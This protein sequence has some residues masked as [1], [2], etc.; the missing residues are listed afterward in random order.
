M[1]DPRSQ[2]QPKGPTA[3]SMRSAP[4]EAF[5]PAVEPATMSEFAPRRIYWS[6]SGDWPR[7]PSFRSS[8]E[9]PALPAG[10]K[11]CSCR[12]SR[13]SY[14]SRLSESTKRG[15]RPNDAHEP[16]Q[17]LMRGSLI[18]S[19]QS[20]SKS[21]TRSRPTTWR[22]RGAE[23]ETR[24]AP[25]GLKRGPAGLGSSYQGGTAEIP[26]AIG[27]VDAL[28]DQLAGSCSASGGQAVAQLRAVN[29]EISEQLA[30]LRHI[31]DRQDPARLEPR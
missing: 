21:R 7:S 23:A 30:D 20:A 3:S 4:A 1:S 19:R 24:K 27:L 6:A 11:T 13:A 12:W 28:D 26:A 8:A 5:R 17:G 14:R 22:P 25:P 15:R 2:A 16:S 18:G 31:V 10:R 29:P 9:R